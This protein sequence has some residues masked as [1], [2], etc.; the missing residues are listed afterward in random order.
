MLDPGLIKKTMGFEKIRM[1][2]GLCLTFEAVC[3][4]DLCSRIYERWLS[5]E[6]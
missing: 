2:K 3:P 1:L 4:K 6:P 5:G